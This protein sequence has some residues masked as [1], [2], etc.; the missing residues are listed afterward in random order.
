[1]SNPSPFHFHQMVPGLD[2]MQNL[3]KGAM[4]AQKDAGHAMPLG[5][6][7]TP[8]LSVEELE[9]RISELKTVLYWLEQNAHAVKTTIQAMEV[10]R[11]TLATL[12]S[13]KVN[14]GELAQAMRMPD[15]G[16][17]PAADAQPAS[18]AGTPA[19]PMAAFM[20]FAKA[21][22]WPG[23]TSAETPSAPA[24]EVPAP[25]PAPAPLF[26]PA[27]APV[28]EPAQPPVEAASAPASSEAHAP[29]LAD[30]MG[31]W[32]A[33]TQ[34]F[35][36]LANAALQGAESAVP[37]MTGMG[38]AAQDMVKAAQ[39]TAMAGAAAVGKAAKPSAKA[40]AKKVAVKSAATQAPAKP[41]AK[42][43]AAKPAT[44]PAA[45]K[46]AASKTAAQKTTRS[47]RRT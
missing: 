21:F 2:F 22:S 47:A 30:P 4:Q 11:L 13:M 9:R 5:N 7:V 37:T 24:A 38:Q 28:A 42:K 43:A 19:N 16:A 40:A 15:L 1:M 18:D 33:L 27:P 6:W 35:Q 17:S 20:P 39:A 32:G 44:K 12:G 26:T 36:T 46:K 34:Q 45:A 41:A 3:M 8:T 23:A 10:Q 25:A 14:L 31:I 29:A